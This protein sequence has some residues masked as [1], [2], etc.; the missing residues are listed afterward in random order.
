MQDASLAET[1][2]SPRPIRPEHQQHRREKI[3]NSKEEKT[4]ITVSIGK[5]DGGTTERHRETRRQ[6][7]HLQYRS[8]K[9]HSG[10]R[11][12]AHGI[13]HH[14]IDGGDFGFLKGLPENR[15]GVYVDRT[16]THKTDVCSTV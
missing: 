7:L 9:T 13:P 5:L 1:R 4:S 11:V 2:Q 16:P 10:R 3:N 12:G 8:G 6:R 15:R 14:L